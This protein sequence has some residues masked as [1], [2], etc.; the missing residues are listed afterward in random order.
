MDEWPL[1][2]KPTNLDIL[3][4]G[5]YGKKK[6][7]S[8]VEE[9]SNNMGVVED[10]SEIATLVK[11][12]Y[13]DQWLRSYN[14]ITMEYNPLEPFTASKET[15]QSDDRDVQK[16]TEANI[17]E[18]LSNDTTVEV[19][20]VETENV[21]S[22]STMNVK[23]SGRDDIGHSSNTGYNIARTV[24]LSQADTVTN[25]LTET[26]DRTTNT[27]NSG[28]DST[29][30][31]SESVINEIDKTN[32][33]DE[34]GELGS[35]HNITKNDTTSTSTSKSTSTQSTA[36]YD[37]DHLK[38]TSKNTDDNSSTDTSKNT[39]NETSIDKSVNEKD[40]TTNTTETGTTTYGKIENVTD[41]VETTSTNVNTI[42]YGK[43]ETTTGQDGRTEAGSNHINY[44]KS[45]N[46]TN[47]E[48]HSKTNSIEG[49][50]TK[51]DTGVNTIGKEGSETVSDNLNRNVTTTE[52]GNKWWSTSQEL[53]TQ[54]L[55]LR[56]SNFYKS[57]VGDVVK[58]LTISV[59]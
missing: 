45:E 35:S 11:E 28:E 58:L 4:I 55:E 43:R 51:T 14:A 29:E 15:V 57:M 33:N 36:P 48:E 26:S 27:T 17:T 38:T 22:D 5:M 44:G 3:L 30:T 47:S 32:L 9:F 52:S 42:S 16:T 12:M 18:N 59:Y 20:S 34:F 10:P 21:E 46:T 7:N 40:S 23:Q 49:T 8:L 56:K 2:M 19:N 1:T 24:E 37:T 53:I 25:E 50:T 13:W 41:G 54:E 31:T 6:V 39:L